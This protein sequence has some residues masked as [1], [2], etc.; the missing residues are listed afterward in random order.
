MLKTK[1]NFIFISGLI[2]A[3]LAISACGDDTSS[4]KPSEYG[5]S[6][7]Y[8]MQRIC[9]DQVRARATFPAEVTFTGRAMRLGESFKKSPDGTFKPTKLAFHTGLA[10][11]TNAFGVKGNFAFSCR[12]RERDGGFAFDD[13][14]LDPRK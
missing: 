10:Q 8:E 9:H 2:L 12:F 6:D 14:S 13:V 5:N 4:D 1:G 7:P 11:M 3:I